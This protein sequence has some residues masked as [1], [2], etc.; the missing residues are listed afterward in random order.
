M[1]FKVLFLMARFL[2]THSR[3]KSDLQNGWNQ[4]Y[5]VLSFWKMKKYILGNLG[6]YLLQLKKKTCLEIR[7]CSAKLRLRNTKPVLRQK[8]RLKTRVDFDTSKKIGVFTTQ[9]DFQIDHQDN[10][11]ENRGRNYKLNWLTVLRQLLRQTNG[12]VDPKRHKA[13]KSKSFWTIWHRS[14]LPK[15]K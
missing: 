15:L 1:I 7:K 2:K 3:S 14:S 12:Q 11:F 5:D 9:S 13:D 10:N 8:A 6:W 4:P